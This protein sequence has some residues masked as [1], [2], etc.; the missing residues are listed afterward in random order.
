[1]ISVE[2]ANA[3][4]QAA[5]RVLP[6][7]QLPLLD[8][9]GS[10]AAT[11]L[12]SS[13]DLPHFD[14]SA[15]DGYAL[16]SADIKSASSE[17]PVSLRLSGI[18]PAGRD[19]TGTLAPGSC[20]RIFTGSILPA[21]ADAVVM[22]EDVTLQGDRVVFTEPARPLENVRLQGEDVKKGAI[23]VR[24]HQQVSPLRL[25]LLAATGHATV[26][27]HR[28]CQV[29]LLATG[30]ELRDPGST[31]HPGEIYESNRTMLAGLIAR[32]NAV[33]ITCPVVPDTLADTATAL[34][35]AFQKADIV[36]STGGVSV[37]EFDFIKD[38]FAKIGGTLEIWKIAMR[39]GKP[40]VFGTLGEKLLFGL[41]GNPVSA[42]VT[43]LLL[44]RPAL[45][46]AQGAADLQLPGLNGI[47]AETISNRGDRRHFAR[48]RWEN[49]RITLAGPQKS[50]M[51]GALADANAL[52]DIPAG[53]EFK[54]GTA[55]QV[56]LWEL[57][58]QN[59]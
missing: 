37:G 56:L 42:F 14:N 52:L 30:N 4:I 24:A 5:V 13:T 48:V 54:V 9:S 46:K 26:P 10:F 45:L 16:R 38:A 53:S 17:N 18:I 44:V 2:E 35:N 22:Q 29:A 28:S 59:L 27:V 33:S 32:L 23:L 12:L 3:R 20:V 11:D 43:F 58:N 40:F 50:H 6:P 19:A 49:G 51:I 8:A 7:V 41:P 1:M 21:G 25:G 39:P 34:A 31:L 55:A 47:L 57:P 36:I 15:M